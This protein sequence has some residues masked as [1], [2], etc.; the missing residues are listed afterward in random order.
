MFVVL[1]GIMGV[2]QKPRF[3]TSKPCQGL[4]SLQNDFW[5]TL[6]FSFICMYSC[7]GI[8]LKGL[9]LELILFVLL[10]YFPLFIEYRRQGCHNTPATFY[11]FL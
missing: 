9:K 11:L 6:I 4:I 2:T 3:R 8:E 10:L 5:V 7:G 1:L